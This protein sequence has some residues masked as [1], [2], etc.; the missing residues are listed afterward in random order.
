MSRPSFIIK[1]KTIYDVTCFKKQSYSTFQLRKGFRKGARCG[2]KV[3]WGE[4]K[5]GPQEKGKGDNPQGLETETE[6]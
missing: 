6:G 1:N 2:L 5:P 3:V 4:G